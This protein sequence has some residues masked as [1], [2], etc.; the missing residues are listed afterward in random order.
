MGVIPVQWPRCAASPAPL[1]VLVRRSSVL[2]PG[3]VPRSTNR[4]RIPPRYQPP[5]LTRT[6]ACRAW[7]RGPA[8]DLRLRSSTHHH[9]AVNSQSR[10]SQISNGS[11]GPQCPHILRSVRREVSGRRRAIGPGGPQLRLCAPTFPRVRRQCPLDFLPEQS[12]NVSLTEATWSTARRCA[13][14]GNG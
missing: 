7:W 3:G 9:V 14:D 13:H 5:T 8:S 6:S 12:V 11:R 4:V 10:P 1:A 2:P